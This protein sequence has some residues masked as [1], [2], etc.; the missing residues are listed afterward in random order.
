MGTGKRELDGGIS[1]PAKRVKNKVIPSSTHTLLKHSEP[2]NTIIFKL[3][4]SHEYGDQLEEGKVI[5]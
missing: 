4:K 2:S 5:N 3:N 1:S